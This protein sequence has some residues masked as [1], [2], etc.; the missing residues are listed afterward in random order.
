MLLKIRELLDS[1]TTSLMD[2][3]QESSKNN[4]SYFFPEII[5]IEEGIKKANKAYLEY[6]RNDFL[7]RNNTC[8]YI[9]KDNGIWVSAMRLYKIKGSIYFMEALETH[10]LYRK[11]GYAEKLISSVIEE[12]KQDGDFEMRSYVNIN[13]VASRRTHI[14]CGF[15]ESSES[16]FDYANNEWVND[17]ILLIYRFDIYKI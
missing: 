13:N 9:W 2:I 5:D 8:Y 4:V 7:K 10:P 11:R 6:I 16:V 12:L 15:E 3:Y 17:A 14:K 1:D